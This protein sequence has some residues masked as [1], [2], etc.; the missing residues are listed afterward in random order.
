MFLC[1][2]CRSDEGFCFHPLQNFLDKL[3][4]RKWYSK[5]PMSY[6]ISSNYFSIEFSSRRDLIAIMVIYLCIIKGVCDTYNYRFSGPHYLRRKLPLVIP[7]TKVCLT[8]DRI[9]GDDYY[10]KIP[11]EFSLCGNKDSASEIIFY[12]EIIL[13]HVSCEHDV[14]LCV[15]LGE[16]RRVYRKFGRSFCRWL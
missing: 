5:F 11:V 10:W 12:S 2:F 1:N 3:P 9:Y 13:L 14:L 6:V 7:N 4:L 16:V 8:Y 15:Q